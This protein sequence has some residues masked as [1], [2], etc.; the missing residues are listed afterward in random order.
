[1]DKPPRKKKDAPVEKAV[2]KKLTPPKPQITHFQIPAAVLSQLNEC[3]GGGFILIYINQ[4]GQPQIAARHDSTVVEI[5]LNSFAAS[6]FNGVQS[7]QDEIMLD[8]VNPPIIVIEDDD[9][10]DGDTT[11]LDDEDEE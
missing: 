3:T 7:T 1:M 10:E 11:F 8:I 6:Y 2:E 5:G 4:A 9:D